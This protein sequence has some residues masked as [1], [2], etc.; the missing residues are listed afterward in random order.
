[1]VISSY[2]ANPVVFR[3]GAQRLREAGLEVE[4]GPLEERQRALNEAYIKH[5]TRGPAL[6][7]A[8]GRGHAGRPARDP[9]GRRPLGLVAE[10]RDYAH[11]L[12]GEHDAIMVGI[13]TILRDDPELTVRHPQWRG[14]TI[15]RVVVDSELRLPLGARLLSRFERGEVIVLTDRPRP[16]DNERALRQKGAE[17]V[18]LSRAPGG[19]DLPQALAW[20]GERGA[21]SLLVEGGS[22]LLT[23]MIE[24]QLAD[25]LF[26]TISPKLVGGEPPPASSRAAAS[27]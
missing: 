5:V 12:R 26:M 1:M 10:A 17:V 18:R 19:V 27:V 25:R 9:D 16:K 8:E 21:A 14:K 3:R 4:V 11:L 13:N 22:R 2:D 7:H 6:R 20:L 24:G 15:L 23:A